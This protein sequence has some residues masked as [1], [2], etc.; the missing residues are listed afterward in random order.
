VHRV[1]GY[2]RACLESVLSQSFPDFEL[3]AVDDRS[4]DGCG[5]ILDEF[6]ERDPRVTVLHLSENVGLG[7]ARNAGMDRAGGDYLLFLDGDDT[8]TPGT[9]EAVERR[10]K[11][12]SDP[13]VLVFD[14]ARSWWWGK[15]QRNRLAHLLRHEDPEVFTARERPEL[16]DLLM[17]VWNK[18][19]RRDFV[20]RHG[21]RFPPGYY[22][23]T[24][25][26]FPVMLSAERIA[27]LDRVCV[28]CSSL[29]RPGRTWPTGGR[30]CTGR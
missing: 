26:T 15:T 20:A 25:W 11:E 22:E 1:Q 14:Y 21:F 10:L 7:R 16:L 29:W 8:W 18:A 23:D 28:T 3:I 19:Y 17:V 24:P 13:Q 27:C 12:T 4:P 6:A 5:E 9:L 30:S 2:V